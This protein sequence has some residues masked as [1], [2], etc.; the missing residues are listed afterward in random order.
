MGVQDMTTARK[1]TAPFLD[2]AKARLDEMDATVTSLKSEAGK[3]KVAAS[4]NAETVL[5]DMLKQRDAFS[6]AIKKQETTAEDVWAKT[7]TALESEWKAFEASLQRYFDETREQTG[8][9]V[10]VFR[11]SAE[12][13][14]KTWLHAIEEIQKATAGVASEQKA[15][16]EAV[17]K[18]MK[19]DAD[20]AKVKLDVLAHAATESWSAYKAGLTATRAAFDH[21][22]QAAQDVFKRAA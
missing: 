16:A 3:L 11:A 22:S 9:Q 13:Q 12:A 5:A 18:R 8:Q 14:R 21:A 6:G 10:A 1:G 2:W 4:K 20:A 19:T 7:K 17:M 15:Q